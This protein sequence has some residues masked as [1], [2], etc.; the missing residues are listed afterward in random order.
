MGITENGSATSRELWRPHP[1]ERACA[2]ASAKSNARARVSKDEDSDSTGLMLRDASQRTWAVEAPA[3]VWRCDAPQHEAGSA[4]HF[5]QTKVNR[6]LSN[7]PKRGSMRVWSA[8]STNLRLHEMTAGAISL[9]PVV[10]YNDVCNSHVPVA[11]NAQ[12]FA[13]QQHA[14]RHAAAAARHI[15]ANPPSARAALR[16]RVERS[17]VGASVTRSNKPSRPH[18]TLFFVQQPCVRFALRDARDGIAP[19]AACHRSRSKRIAREELCVLWLRLSR[20]RQSLMT[21][22]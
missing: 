19:P 12:D 8:R 6:I 20:R 22:A 3:L 14:C 4:A 2:S 5:G 7:E 17:H 16:R 10:I 11:S 18:S 9:F 15:Q 13:K 21:H 1:E